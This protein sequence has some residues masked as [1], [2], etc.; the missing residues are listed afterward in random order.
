[1]F[2]E[3]VKD[4]FVDFWRHLCLVKEWRICLERKFESVVVIWWQLNSVGKY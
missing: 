1:M 3:R 4:M 2:C